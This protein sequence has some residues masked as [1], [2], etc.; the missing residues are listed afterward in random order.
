MLT[1]PPAV[2][3]AP[4]DPPAEGEQAPP[5][6]QQNPPME[7]LTPPVVSHLNQQIDILMVDD[8][9][10][11]NQYLTTTHASGSTI[12]GAEPMRLYGSRYEA[13]RS[14]RPVI[15][16]SGNRQQE[17]VE[18]LHAEPDSAF[19]AVANKQG[20]PQEVNFS[21]L[22]QTVSWDNLLFSDSALAQL[23][24][25]SPG[26]NI[27]F[28][29]HKKLSNQQEIRVSTQV[30][31]Q[32]KITLQRPDG[33]VA[34]CHSEVVEGLNG[35]SCHI[36][37]I[38]A[39]LPEGNTGDI[40]FVLRSRIDRPGVHYRI[41]Q[42]WMPSGT[43]VSVAEFRQ[44]SFLELF[45]PDAQPNVHRTDNF[46]KL[47]NLLEAGFYSASRHTQGDRFGIALGG[48]SL[49]A[50]ESNHQLS[51]LEYLVIHD[52]VRG[53][54]YITTLNSNRLKKG[55]R[56]A[57]YGVFNP[58]GGEKQAAWHISRENAPLPSAEAQIVPTEDF[59]ASS[60]DEG[61]TLSERGWRTLINMAPG[62]SRQW[63]YES[64]SAAGNLVLMN[65][66]VKGGQLTLSRPGRVSCRDGEV[67]GRQGK[68]CLLRELSWQGSAN[69]SSNLRF[70][71]STSLNAV[72]A[73]YRVE[74][75]WVRL[76]DSVP[77]SD[78]AN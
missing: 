57:L 72:D 63:R 8:Q 45:V 12:A 73:R 62:D 17:P 53:E 41:G 60:A 47:G 55:L 3:P 40:L 67:E 24:S 9:V 71:L 54:H 65:H 14:R 74:G 70:K 69:L 68:I 2:L 33:G 49:P 26:G 35:T 34:R 43:P 44:A 20:Q 32:G 29:L 23:T 39:E 58:R 48:S 1:S 18:I 78:L 61:I 56:T 51:R 15:L 37:K 22:P 59:V 5:P 50:G 46:A 6:E 64:H 42:Q 77:I 36:R 76:G 75:E 21:A 38:T 19:R 31:Q 28:S 7:T 11:G 13:G 16:Y 52:Q 4:I 27:T 30:T 10:A 25:L 66:L